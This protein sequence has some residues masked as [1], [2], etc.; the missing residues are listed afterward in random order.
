MVSKCTSSALPT[1][2][3]LALAALISLW[4]LLAAQNANAQATEPRFDVLVFS[5]TTGFRHTEAINAGHAQIAAMG[6]AGNFRTVASED[7]TLFSDEGLREFEVVV[8]L[9]TDGN[10]IFSG[11]QR[12]A[13]ERWVQR[14][15]GVVG[16]H[17][18]ANAD[19]DGEWYGDMMGG[20][21]FANHP[22]GALQ[23]QTATV[24]V[25]DGQHPSTADLPQPN[26]VRE[27][28]WYNFT[29]EPQ[30]V[31]PLLKLDEST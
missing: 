23:F 13:F 2:L 28:E 24:N 26:W 27:D 22:S 1:W 16:I 12:T 17:A 6:Q 14:G 3:C 30:G 31:H 18:A 11:A 9:N 8:F 25:V 19:R 20:A 4:A 21:W 7:S 10:G 5:K 15:G 29:A